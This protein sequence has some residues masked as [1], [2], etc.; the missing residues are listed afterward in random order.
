MARRRSG[1]K[2][3]TKLRRTLRRL[4]EALTASVKREMKEGAEAVGDDA[5]SGVPV[6]TGALRDAL[7]VKMSRDGFSARIGYHPS[8]PG[9][10]RAWKKAGW[11]AHFA[12]FGVLGRPGAFFLSNA[13]ETNRRGLLKNIGRAISQTVRR[14]AAT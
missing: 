9:F 7:L 10:K 11:R 13:W 2:G 5:R 3:V 8:A 6:R 14:A 1:L 12:E 4:P